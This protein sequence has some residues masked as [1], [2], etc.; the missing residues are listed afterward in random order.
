MDEITCSKG[1]KLNRGVT[2]ER[3]RQLTRALGLL[4]VMAIM[5]LQ[6]ATAIDIDGVLPT[7]I[8]LPEINLLIRPSDGAAPFMGE[9]F[10][11]SDLINLR[12]IYDTGASGVVLFEGPAQALGI[13]VAQFNGSDIIF[14]DVGVGGTAEFFVSDPIHLSLGHFDQEPPSSYNA[15]TENTTYPRQYGD[16]RLQL[17]PPGSASIFLS[18]FTQMGIAGMPLMNGLVSVI[19]PKLAEVPF[20]ELTPAN[21]IHTYVYDPAQA[22]ISGPGILSPDVHVAL[23]LQSFDQFTATS[24]AGASGP[25]LNANPFIGPDPLAAFNGETTPSAPP[26]IT[27]SLDGLEQTGSFLLDTGN[28]TSSISSAMAAGLNVRYVAGTEG[29]LTPLLEIFDPL[30]PLAPG[31]L[32]ADQFTQAFSGIGGTSVI[33]GFYLDSLL[34]RTIE[35]DPGN[36]LDPQHLNFLNAPIFVQDIKL[37]E[38]GTMNTFIFDGILGTNFL[39]G[40]GDLS[41]LSGFPAAFR[42]GA[43]DALILDFDATNPSLGLQLATPVPVPPLGYF[44]VVAVLSIVRTKRA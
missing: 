33:A 40:S 37:T 22:P 16:V 9:D 5:P 13:P 3:A 42:E 25:S 23:T 1:L 39:F 35:G 20:T 17:G 14:S 7:S 18:D 19:Q 12:M 15:A 4:A 32:I 8:G 6:S 34:V 43:F 21:T 38:A 10:V 24:P 44:F 41:A 2:R 27:V 11:G 31:S 30:N 26:G 36:D 28:Q 29:T